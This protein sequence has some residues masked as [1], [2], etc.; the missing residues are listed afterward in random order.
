MDPITLTVLGLGAAPAGA[1]FVRLME[2]LCGTPR[3]EDRAREQQREDD[4]TRGRSR[5]SAGR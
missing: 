1:A 4:E 5:R 3:D 2:K